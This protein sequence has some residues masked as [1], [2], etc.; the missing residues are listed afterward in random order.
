MTIYGVCQTEKGP[1]SLPA[2]LLKMDTQN[3]SATSTT[4]LSMFGERETSL[5][6]GKMQLLRSFIKR[7]IALIATTTEGFRLLPI[8]AKYCYKWSRPA[9]AIIA[10]PKGYSPRNSAA[11]APRDLQWTCCS[12]CADCKNSDEPGESCASSISRKHMTPSTESCC[13]WCSH[14]SAYQRRC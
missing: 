2:E 8:E 7:R 6:S 10:R 1:D 13:G 3:L 9:S 5:S 14:A 4:Y 12:S 11:F